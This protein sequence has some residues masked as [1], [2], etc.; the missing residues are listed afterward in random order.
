M[1]KTTFA[2]VL[3]AACICI[4][5]SGWAGEAG[6]ASS[7][8]EAMR[9]GKETGRPIMI[10]FTSPACGPCKKM[11]L[12]VFT[13]PA[14]KAELDKLVKAKADVTQPDMK[15]LSK[16]H[17]FTAV[18]AFVF[19]RP[20]GTTVVSRQDLSPALP[21]D[22]LRCV[23]SVLRRES[24]L[25]SA[26]KMAAASPD[27]TRLAYHLGVAYADV[28]ENALAREQFEKLL[29]GQPCASPKELA[30][31]NYRL[32]QAYEAQGDKQK[33]ASLFDAAVEHD[34][35]DKY[36]LGAASAISRGRL[37]L[38]AGDVRTAY[39][40]FGRVMKKMNAGKGR[41]AEAVYLLGMCYERM[42]NNQ[43][44]TYTWKRGAVMYPK[45]TYGRKCASAGGPVAP[46]RKRQ[47]R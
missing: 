31:A 11:E 1:K 5:T 15:A 18:P 30:D 38:A 34:P 22:F 14:V 8:A 26:L 23:Q 9:I 13:L 27:N 44:A 46:P 35:L 37:A 33:A 29:A 40:C 16:K 12:E 19:A 20:N 10:E 24:A 3:C 36:K 42:G 41:T 28:A 7:V 39:K 6:W 45:T 21:E 17:G 4:S 47:G 43:A 25:A 2:E 32:A